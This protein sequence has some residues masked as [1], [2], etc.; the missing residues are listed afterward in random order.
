MSNGNTVTICGSMGRD[1]DLRFTPTGQAVAT[2]SVAVNRRW[3][4]RQTQEWREDTD[5]IDCVAWGSLAE[6]CAESLTKGCRVIVTGRFSQRSWNTEDGQKRSKVEVVADEV[7]PSLRWATCTVTRT[8]KQTGYDTA[9]PQPAAAAST[10]NGP[11]WGTDEE[12]FIVG[13]HDWVPGSWG[14]YP[15]K[16]FLPQRRGA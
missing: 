6:N 1:P 16:R 5:W 4:D 2:F 14:S 10:P 7:G 13:V 9:P 8:E 12:P 11:G 3:Q 15:S